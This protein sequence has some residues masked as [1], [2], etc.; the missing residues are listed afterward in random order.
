VIRD[1]WV[2][3][4]N[5]KLVS[6][7][8]FYCVSFPVSDNVRPTTWGPRH[9]AH[10]VWPNDVGPTTGL[11]R[12]RGEDFPHQYVSGTSSHVHRQAIGSQRATVPMVLKTSSKLF[13]ISS[14]TFPT[15]R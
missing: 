7:D 9:G 8:Y 12:S 2:F 14:F 3:E 10:N 6:D 13:A 15:D 4:D 11:P 5:R 1:N